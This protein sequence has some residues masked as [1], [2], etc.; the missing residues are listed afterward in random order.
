MQV[1]T[2]D[3]NGLITIVNAAT[4]DIYGVEMELS[5]TPVD[6]FNIAGTAA[7]LDATYV[8]F[9]GAAGND[10]SGNRLNRAPEWQLSLMAQ[11]TFPIAGFGTLTPRV[12]WQYVDELFHD[13]NNTQPPGFGEFRHH[14]RKAAL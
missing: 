5:A 12:E 10:L 11:Y 13:E 14:Q 1:R 8:E 6:N 4:A 2:T 7:W 9:I 3:P